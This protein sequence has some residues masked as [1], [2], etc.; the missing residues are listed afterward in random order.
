MIIHGQPYV[1]PFFG[2]QSP[3]ER[4]VEA[5]YRT[6]TLML[7]PDG[8]RCHEHPSASTEDLLEL[9]REKAGDRIFRVCEQI[10]VRLPIR[11][12]NVNGEIG[13]QPYI[14]QKAS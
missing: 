6:V 5:Q 8:W 7:M 9:V 10:S 2:A 4:L 13:Y 12:V 14:P 3:D 11:I 1:P